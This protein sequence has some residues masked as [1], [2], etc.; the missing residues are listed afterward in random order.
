[1]AGYTTGKGLGPGPKIKKGGA[2]DP[3]SKKLAKAPAVKVKIR[4]HF[5]FEC[6]VGTNSSVA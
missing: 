5:V 3:K 4:R 1:M 6:L 2:V